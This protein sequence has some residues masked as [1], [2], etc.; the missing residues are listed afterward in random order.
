M[1]VDEFRSLWETRLASSEPWID[2]IRR[3]ISDPKSYYSSLTPINLCAQTLHHAGD[4][5][6]PSA[7]PCFLTEWSLFKVL[8]DVSSTKQPLILDVLLERLSELSEEEINA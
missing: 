8:L 4:E 7:Q 2:T 1:D 6:D 3:F 5:M